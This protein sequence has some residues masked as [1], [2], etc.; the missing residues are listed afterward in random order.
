MDL[1]AL[2]AYL[3][4]RIGP[5][6]VTSARQTFPGHSRQTWILDTAEQGGLV[7]RV[8]HPGGP[9]VPVPMS[10]EWAVY[11]RLWGSQ[12]PVAEPLMY[13]EGT[14][15]AGGRAHMVRRL[16]DGSPNVE[17]IT[18]E[19]GDDPDLLRSACYE[20][21]EKL[22]LVHTLDWR[23]LGLG[24]VVFV[25]TSPATALVE[26][27]RHWR[28]LWMGCRCGPYPMLTEATW[29]LEEQIPATEPRLVFLKG[30]NGFGEEI[31][32]D[33]RI[34]ALSDWELAQVGDP[35]LDWAFSQGLLRLN[36]L[37][38]TLR[39][40]EAA[41]GFAIDRELLAWS[42]VWIRVKASMTTNGGL[43]AFVDGTDNRM[44]RAALG[45]G[46]IRST[47]KWMAGALGRDVT[48]VG[49]EMLAQLRSAYLGV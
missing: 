22:A 46:V 15:F 31:W 9:L 26:E 37:D 10:T 7:L 20:V 13:A 18:G 3:S 5:V 36:D 41:A 42:A 17:G 27:V 25:P 49:F 16:V 28:S 23:A 6:T 33:G 19:P 47:E 45:M 44:A 30:N 39:H 32:R 1:T 40:Y 34:V 4:G 12:V 21:A 29:W 35:A 48:D 11:E 8:D 2:S 24:E 43:G 38:D 14:D